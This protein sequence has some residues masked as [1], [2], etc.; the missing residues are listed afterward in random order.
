MDD[1][2]DFYTITYSNNILSWHMFN[3]SYRGLKIA[4]T[5]A[6]MREMVK[7]G[8]D[9]YFVVK[10]L[11]WG[12][13]APRKRKEGTIE[14][15]MDKGSKTFNAVIVKDYDEVIKEDCWVLIHLGKFSRR[16]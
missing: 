13:D 16:N 1:E 12:Y 11:E 5:D 4:V 3:R 7:H 9:M 15:W 2:K 14:K 6:A 10:I 8:R